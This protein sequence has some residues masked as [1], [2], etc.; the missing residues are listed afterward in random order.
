MA[1]GR[2]ATDPQA[3]FAMLREY[4]LCPGR[5]VPETETLS[6]WRAREMRNLGIAVEV[7]E[8]RQAHA[9]KKLQH[10]KTNAND[11]DVLVRSRAR[12]SAARWR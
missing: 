2:V 10:H 11:A 12:I 1:R 5:I 3:L 7:I 9:V 4:C 8:A 6:G